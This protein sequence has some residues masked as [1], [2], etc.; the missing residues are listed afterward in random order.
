MNARLRIDPARVIGKID[1]NIYG[2]F[3]S[4]RPGCS[5]G[6]LYD[7]TAATADQH[8]IRRDVSQAIAAL[9]PPLI[10][11]PG[12]CTGTSYHWQDGVGPVADRPKKIDL[13]FGWPARYE[14]G[15]AEFI[16]WC[17]SIGAEPHLNLAMGTG[18]LEEAAAW[19]EYCNSD[20][21]TYYANLRRRHGQETPYNV[22]YWQLGNETYGPWE[23]GHCSPG[24]Y[25][26]QAREWG[27]VL[28]R[29]DPT[30]KLLAVGGAADDD[31]QWAWEVL[32]EVA[33]YVDYV[34]FHTYWHSAGAAGA[35]PWYQL[36]AGPHRAER[37]IEQLAAIAETVYRVGPRGRRPPPR[38]LRVACTEWNTMPGTDFMASH[39][40]IGSFRP[41]YHLHDALAV[42]TFANVMQRQCREITLATIAQSINVVGL[43][44]VDEQGMWL[45]PTY[46][47]WQMAVNHSGPLALDAWLEG[48][49]FDV[50]QHRLFNLPYVDASVT[51]DPDAGQLYLSLVNRHQDQPVRLDIALA[52]AAV[53]SGGRAYILHH[54]DPQ[55]MNGHD[56]PENVRPHEHALTL[57]GARLSY[58]VL[59][60][61][62]AILA[63][64]LG[65]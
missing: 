32:P 9:R 59:P 65:V 33:P 61:S 8:G 18:T 38:R 50:P 36:L 21:D 12:G 17:R 43:I 56:R 26:T 24:E 4:R 10:R 39:T 63:L 45:E 16:A 15:S 52:D 27:K 3:L 46:W 62:Y 5:E 64:P 23:I 1:P 2:Q 19:L 6:G 7:P 44:M 57:E 55:A 51:L 37:K 47:A 14:F 29:L 22:K 28:R 35:D 58:E 13:H 41:S 30:I 54:D 48:D 31:G 25:A 34:T 60:H 20:Y 42:A 40:G 11:W 49:T 53:R